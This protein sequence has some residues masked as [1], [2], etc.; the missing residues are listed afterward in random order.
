[1][2]IL[3]SGGS[4]FIGSAFSE[5]L[6]TKQGNEV[7]IT[8][9]SR[10]KNQSHPS[11]IQMMSYE[12]LKTTEL[13][14]DVIINLAGAGIADKRW[15]D[16]RK[17]ALFDSRVLP[18]QALLEYIKRIQQKPRLLISG[19]AIGWYGA[20][21]SKALDETSEHHSKHM[22]PEAH[23]EDFAHQLCDSW[24][25]LAKSATEMGVE[26]IIVR[27]GIVI[28]PSGGMLG[29]L[30]PAFKMGVGGQ[31]G[32]GK[33]VMSWISRE[34]WIRAAYFII[35]RHL[36]SASEQAVSGARDPQVSIYNLTSPN[37]VNNAVFTKTVGNW[38]NK[39][40]IMTLPKLAL[41]VMFG[42]MSTLLV[43][44][45]KVLPQALLDA[46]FV[47]K[48]PQLSDALTKQS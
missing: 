4:G 13:S 44:G 10:D 41:K 1:M 38:L 3:I 46:G 16:T 15:S 30:I 22:Q 8:W 37:P 36:S 7:E 28:H 14:F 17:R 32:D 33:Q 20:Q 19:S 35:D 43:D 18:T 29:K 23:K 31:L 5:W 24:E 42:E 26:V 21:G 27:T 9:L 2:N 39:L 6:N 45:Q 40:T 34:D 47:F 48:H 11:Y 12:E 25:E